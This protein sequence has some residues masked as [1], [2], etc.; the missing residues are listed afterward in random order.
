M[1]GIIIGNGGGSVD[2]SQA[3]ATTSNVLY[4][5]T[6]FSSA[7]DEVQT[8]TFASQEKSVSPTT[9]AQTVTPDNGRWLSSVTVGAVSLTGNATASKVISGYTFYSNSLTKQTGTC[10]PKLIATQSTGTHSVTDSSATSPTADGGSYWKSTVVGAWQMSAYNSSS[11]S[12]TWYIQGSNN[13]STW[14]NVS[15]GT[16]SFTASGSQV[17]SFVKSLNPSSSQQY[18]YWRTYHTATGG[19]GGT[20][21]GSSVMV[22]GY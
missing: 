11:I 9:S 22:F 1:E 4:G 20:N 3:D 5:K 17:K 13:G 18:R 19:G 16:E 12:L 2:L 6:F 7:S 21:S 8:G 10:V 14:T 15:S